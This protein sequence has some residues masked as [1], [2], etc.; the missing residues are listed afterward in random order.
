MGHGTNIYQPSPHCFSHFP[1]KFD[2]SKIRSNKKISNLPNFNEMECNHDS[3]FWHIY[4]FE[5]TP[6]LCN[7]CYNAV[8]FFVLPET[9]LQHLYKSYGQWSKLNESILSLDIVPYK[10]LP[11]PIFDISYIHVPHIVKFTKGKHSN[12]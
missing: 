8:K 5:L 2:Q 9:Y 11:L 10:S 3:I 1:P 12:S 6:N 4:Q 7:W